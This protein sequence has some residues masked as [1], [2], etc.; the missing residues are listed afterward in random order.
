MSETSE[1]TGNL[2]DIGYVWILNINRVPHN[3]ISD[4]SREYLQMQN[5]GAPPQLQIISLP[6]CLSRSIVR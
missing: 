3:A 2:P 1:A 6:R 4:R 5:I